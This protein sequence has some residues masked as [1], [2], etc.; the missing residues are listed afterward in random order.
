MLL[1]GKYPGTHPFDY[2]NSS[3]A[4]KCR[5]TRPRL[6]F[7]VP[8]F[9][10]VKLYITLSLDDKKH[11]LKATNQI[12]YSW[13]QLCITHLDLSSCRLQQS[14]CGLALRELNLSHLRYLLLRMNNLPAVPHITHP[15][16]LQLI[17]VPPLEKL[18]HKL[19]LEGVFLFFNGRPHLLYDTSLVLS[20]YPI[21]SVT[22]NGPMQITMSGVMH[23]VP[24]KYQ[25]PD[26]QYLQLSTSIFNF[27]PL[28][29]LVTCSQLR[30]LSILP[31][32]GHL[33]ST[34]HGVCDVV[35]CIS[36][37]SNLAFLEW[38]SDMNLRTGDLLAFH[39]ALTASM[40]SLDHCHIR[41][42]FIL[43]ST[44]DLENAQF[45]P[46]ISVLARHLTDL[47]GD[48][49]CSTFKFT[50]DGFG[51]REW[52]TSLRPDVCFRMKVDT[53]LSYFV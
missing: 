37:L 18:S 43:L 27:V 36:Q 42:P 23:P 34:Y 39:H 4:V 49:S 33:G 45:S 32:I 13:F 2:L 40:F 44:T 9:Q 7:N 47:E 51:L 38:D 1:R 30:V 25:S 41:F 20:D 28:D 3:D 21:K 19:T 15:F 6:P 17:V 53:H 46:I 11:V 14:E 24:E 35:R 52:L 48:D 16:T 22:I 8:T 26:L 5:R 50:L 29:Y 10:Q 31:G 12:E